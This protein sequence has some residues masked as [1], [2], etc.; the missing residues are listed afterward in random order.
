MDKKA[1]RAHMLGRRSALLLEQ[2]EQLSRLAQQRLLATELFSSVQSM[3]LY[4]PIHNEIA[5][6]EIFA[7]AC[8]QGKLVYYPRVA[9][10]ALH[11][12]EINS[13]GQLIPGSFGVLEPAAELNSSQQV[14]DL[15]LVPGVA[16][17]R[18]GHRLGYGRGFYDRYLSRFSDQVVR[19]GFSYSFQLCDAL[20]VDAHDQSL[21]VLVTDT[22]TITWRNKL[23][24]LT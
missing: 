7:A 12:V 20:P 1:I 21:D 23:P 24:G 11:F 18:F 9:G 3:A 2:V 22:E 5:T 4:S 10:E 16:F 14:P 6:S 15:I 8:R 19:V 17:D 13:P